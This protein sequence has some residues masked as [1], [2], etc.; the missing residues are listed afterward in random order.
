MDLKV[1]CAY[2][3]VLGHVCV[4][5]YVFCQD[6]FYMKL[7]VV[8]YI[9]NFLWSTPVTF[10]HQHHNSLKAAQSWAEGVVHWS[11]STLLPQ[12]NSQGLVSLPRN[13]EAIRYSRLPFFSA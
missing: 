10:I 9:Q 3:S 7:V 6:L 11:S 2:V 13:A 4:C 12:H 1:C 8:N 5:M